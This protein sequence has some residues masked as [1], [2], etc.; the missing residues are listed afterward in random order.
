MDN[1]FPLGAA[2]D[3]TPAVQND[4]NYTDLTDT[5]NVHLFST[6]A[7]TTVLHSQ[8]IISAL[9]LIDWTQLSQ[10]DDRGN[11]KKVR[12]AHT[13]ERLTAK[14][15]PDIN[16]LLH[17]YHP[18]HSGTFK[19]DITIHHI[20]NGKTYIPELEKLG[21]V[22]KGL[23][24]LLTSAPDHIVRVIKE[25]DSSYHIF[26]S[27]YDWDL[28][29]K[30]VSIIPLLFPDMFLPE[31]VKE[32]LKALGGND[33][34]KYV[35][36][37]NNYIAKLG[38]REAKMKK[39]LEKLSENMLA[40]QKRNLEENINNIK[41]DIDSYMKGIST[42]YNRLREYEMTLA[43]LLAQDAS[44]DLVEFV[45]YIDRHK[46]VEL[47][48]IRDTSLILKASTTF[49]Y[50]DE[51]LLNKIMNNSRT[52]IGCNGYLKALFKAVFIDKTIKMHIQV[53]FKLNLNNRTVSRYT[54]RNI[55]A[56]YYCQPHIYNFDCWGNN[57]AHII[58][59]LNEGQYIAAL[60]QALAAIMNINFADNTVLGYFIREVSDGKRNT[61]ALELQDGTRITFKQFEDKMRAEEAIIE[62]EKLAKEREEAK[63][64]AEEEARN[65]ELLQIA[66]TEP[67]VA[68]RPSPRR[69][70]T[71]PP[72]PPTQAE[73][74][75]ETVEPEIAIAITDAIQEET[76][77]PFTED[78]TFEEFEGDEN[79]D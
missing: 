28:G 50:F 51:V 27:E 68:P 10:K 73:I 48:D 72:T 31:E 38:I 66:Q 76:A 12:I 46:I 57:Q 7:L 44:A 53:Y 17:L 49:R 70:R 15:I 32:I 23:S 1:I 2:Y 69:R 67:E 4:L 30:I 20:Y 59:A 16:N 34:V 64:K 36:L 18:L 52:D 43:G 75:E 26:T 65:Q 8:V 47:V 42:S 14:K 29:R 37:Y 56:T 63:R 24:T 58:K 35:T 78:I 79:N 11:Y 22:N 45:D 19:R 74:T 54:D 41:Y 40:K 25:T 39:A 33:Y 71:V 9:L 5:C 6:R 13:R 60:E 3:N 21:E 55:E 62:A 61:P 77:E